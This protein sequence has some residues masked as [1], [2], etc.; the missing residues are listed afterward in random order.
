MLTELEPE[1]LEVSFATR[2]GLLAVR[3]GDRLAMDF[4]SRPPT[5][6]EAPPE[7]ITGLGAKPETVLKSRD[8]LAV[9]ASEDEVRNLQPDFALLKRLPSLGVIVTAAGRDVDFVS[10]FFAPQAGIDE[11]PVTGSAHSTLIPYWAERLG[12]KE[13]RARQISATGRRAVVYRPRRSRRDRGACRAVFARDDPPIGRGSR[14]RK[15]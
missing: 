12:K 14:A 13:L 8:F 10:R 1:L 9:Y 2:S 6:C 4:P 3:A 7:L 5:P 15:V 11:D